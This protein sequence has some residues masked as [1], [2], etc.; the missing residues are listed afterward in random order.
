M[1][2]AA[3]ADARSSDERTINHMR[4]VKFHFSNWNGIAVG[5]DGGAKARCRRGG[6]SSSFSESC[7]PLAER[8]VK[9]PKGEKK[10]EKRLTSTSVCEHRARSKKGKRKFLTH[11]PPFS[12]L[13]PYKEPL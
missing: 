7:R 5:D 6:G 4:R 13:P 3:R 9:V 8:A 12:D 10:R 2:L 11:L 1:W